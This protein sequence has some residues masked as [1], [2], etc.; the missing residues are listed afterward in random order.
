MNNSQVHYMQE[1]VPELAFPLLSES[2]SVWDAETILGGIMPET[3]NAEKSD[4]LD[5]VSAASISSHCPVS[6]FLLQRS[7]NF[8]HASLTCNKS[9]IT[10]Q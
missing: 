5:I 2:N 1:I 3:F 10:D 8:V 7:M 6:C 9:Y 4:R